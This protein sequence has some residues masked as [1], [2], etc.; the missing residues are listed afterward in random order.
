MISE[1][2]SNQISTY[3]LF[4]SALSFGSAV[5]KKQLYAN[6]F[7]DFSY[8]VIIIH[9]LH[10]GP[11]FQLSSFLQVWHQCLLHAPDL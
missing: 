9:L 4:L 6:Y 10:P 7:A 2:S 3:S 11:Q 8:Y 5:Q 1:Y